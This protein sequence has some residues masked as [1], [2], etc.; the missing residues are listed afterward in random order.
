MKEGKTYPSIIHSGIDIVTKEN[1]DDY[2]IKRKTMNFK[3][4]QAE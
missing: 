2:A 4:K 1:V 3:E